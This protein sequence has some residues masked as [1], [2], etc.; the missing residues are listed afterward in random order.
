MLTDAAAP[1]NTLPG[2]P[3]AVKR[4]HE[5]GGSSLA[6]GLRNLVTD[7]RRNGGM[8]SQVDP[9]AFA[10]G[11][12]LRADGRRGRVPQRRAGVDPVPATD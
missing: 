5:T 10:V 4:L 8:P 2:N 12:N 9:A 1:T 11:E 6:Y 7:A 3:Q